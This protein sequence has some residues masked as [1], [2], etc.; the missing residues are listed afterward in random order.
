[1]L[2]S[3]WYQFRYALRASLHDPEGGSKARFFSKFGFTIENW[4][5]LAQALKDHALLDSGTLI[6]ESP[7]GHKYQVHGPLTCPDG[8]SPL[9]TSIWII[10]KSTEKPRLVTA[11]PS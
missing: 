2:S 5:L 7:F 1:V 4:T 3:R 9:I 6:S 11:Y 8:R 10:E